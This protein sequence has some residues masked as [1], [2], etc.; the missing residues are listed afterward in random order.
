MKPAR[1]LPPL[2]RAALVL[3][4]AVAFA[5]LAWSLDRRML[6]V[7]Q[8]AYFGFR[9]VFS[10][11]L[12]GLLGALVLVVLTRR[13]LLSLLVVAGLQALVYRIGTVKLQVLNDPIGLQDLY[14]LTNL[15][16]ASVSLLGAYVERPYLVLGGMVALGALA[17]MAWWLER[18]AFRAFRW[19]HAGLAL[20]AIGLCATL[21]A[22]RAPWDQ[23]YTKEALRPSRFQAMTAILHGGQMSSLV[24]SHIRNRRTL[25]TLDEA[26]LSRLL[27]EVP[28]PAA[29]AP[30]TGAARPDVVVFLSESLFDPWRMQGMDALPDPV[31]EVRAAIA[32]GHG[33]AM[34]APT[35]GGGTVR[36]EFE[37]LTGM[38]VS[39][40]P[41][42]RYPYVSLVRQR[43]PGLV[44]QLEAH[45]YRSVAIHG[46]AGSFWNR[47]NAYRAMGFD[48]F[49][50]RDDFPADAPR[51]G[52]YFSDTATT[53]LVL[54]E[55]DRPAG[56]PPQLVVA[57]SIEAHGP[58]RHA[59]EADTATRDAIPV[60]DVLPPK[61]AAE[62]RDYLYHARHADAQFGR[63]LRELEARTRPTVVL[64]FGDHLPGF[65]G[66]YERLPFQDGE[67]RWR[68]PVPW[69]I[70]RSDRPGQALDAPSEMAAWML[71]GQL[72]RVAGLDDD[73]WFALTDAV[74][75]R[76]DGAPRPVQGRLMRGLEAAAVA[77][78]NGSLGA[79]LEAHRAATTEQRP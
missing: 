60:P 24:Y 16:P 13:P 29:A 12:P 6:G 77:R 46:N 74:A 64:F 28:V 69:V 76:L 78:L 39:A 47:T 62:L 23:L 50:T 27:D 37:V 51:D 68:Q 18:P 1:A 34:I 3:G 45:G 38:P 75:R 58:Y 71:P 48:R 57:I 8:E 19:T 52:R 20:L 17:G 73:A 4:A 32:A 26:A 59:R 70:W 53:D 22:A 55:L 79:R 35:F 40:F 9:P 21:V 7:A 36:T 30:A 67:S 61:E 5:L 56:A 31:P 65:T 54:R 72:L 33:G 25:D 43:I 15:S 49:L 2:P 14:F 10:N 42:A 63:L 11:A 44:S 41:D 66:I